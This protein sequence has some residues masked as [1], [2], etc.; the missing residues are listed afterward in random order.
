M[1]KKTLF[2]L[3]IVIAV[4]FIGFFIF[5]FISF[6]KSVRT[7]A[8]S[9]TENLKSAAGQLNNFELEKAQDSFQS[10]ND[11]I[12]SIHSRS[13]TFGLTAFEEARS[14]F[15]NLSL[16]GQKA[17]ELGQN[18]VELSGGGFSWFINQQG[19]KLIG[20]L[21]NLKNN[22]NQLALI[23]G[24][25]QSQAAES[26]Y[27]I[28]N[29]YLNVSADLSN[30]Q[31][32][33]DALVTWLKLPS[34]GHF[35][36]FFQNSSEIRPGGGFI[37]S[38]ADLTLRNGGLANIDVR[39]IYD[40]DGQLDWKIIP[41]KPLQLIT[42]NWGARDANWFFDFPLSAQKVIQFLEA[43]KIYREKGVK[44]DGA[45]AV[46]IEVVRDILA[47]TGPVYLAE[48]QLNV[49]RDNF[50][51]EVQKEVE[52]GADKKAGQ[53]KKILKVLT[54]LILEKLA[55]LDD[56][57]KQT[58]V[59]SLAKR[60]D[61]KDIM[62]YFKDLAMESYLK[63]LGVAGEMMNLPDGFVGD[64]LA[65]VNAN[66]SGHKTDAFVV[67]KIKTE[68]RIDDDGQV[69]TNLTIERRHNGQDQPEWWYRAS[70]QSYLQ[71][72]LPLG[73][74]ISAVQ[75]N[76]WKVVNS[77]LDYKKFGYR[78]DDEVAALESSFKFVNGFNA[79]EFSLWQ[80]SAFATWLTVKAGETGVLEAAYSNPVRLN[81][82]NSPVYT[83]IFEKQSGVNGGLEFTIQAPANYAWKEN[84]RSVFRYETSDPPARLILK[85]TLSPAA[86]QRRF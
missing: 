84:G 30:N 31:R 82:E 15:A 3:T 34:G 42:S 55:G 61:R 86:G 53:P 51:A 78:V 57:Q 56:R 2:I 50:L 79:A 10:V 28:G 67:Q 12:Q 6:K 19:E 60:F 68:S 16:L 17:V 1:R 14:A 71:V 66:I 40:P 39:D 37:G 48:Y 25:L 58:L 69:T 24:E 45:L 81:L 80:K 76:E 85:M 27:Y 43:S 63:D 18:L 11:G 59:S 20:K 22:L 70:N 73:S 83:F 46:N 64:Y 52:T 72:F 38:Y 26:G 9:V 29:D 4:I 75:G 65:V 54:P 77:P 21:E 33:L 44:F 62:V 74:K 7:A 13:K 23:S 32:F 5:S 49:D 36:L 47:V 41:P 8:L 35:L